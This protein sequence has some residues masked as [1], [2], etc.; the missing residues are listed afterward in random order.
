MDDH[1]GEKHEAIALKLEALTASFNLLAQ[2]LQQVQKDNQETRT[3]LETAMKV[4]G[5]AYSQDA[6]RWVKKEKLEA[7]QKKDENG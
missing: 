6:N 3:S 1:H 4:L 2:R 7:L 5:Y